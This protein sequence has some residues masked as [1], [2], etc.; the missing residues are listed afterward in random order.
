[1]MA[2]MFL[3]QPEGDLTVDE[4]IRVFDPED[5]A[6]DPTTPGLEVIRY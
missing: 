2:L 5:V 3:V 4:S 6:D 1:M